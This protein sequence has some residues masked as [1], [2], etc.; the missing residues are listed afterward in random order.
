MSFTEF[1]KENLIVFY[2]IVHDT[3]TTK[4]HK[5]YEAKFQLY[6]CLFFIIWHN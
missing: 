1:L 3:Q 5:R 2:T 4:I 6:F